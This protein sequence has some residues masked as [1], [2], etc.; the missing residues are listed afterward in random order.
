MIR[1]LTKKDFHNFVDFCKK[2]DINSDFYITKNEKRL[3]L[4]DSKVATQIFKDCLKG[5]EKCFVK[6]DNDSITGILLITGYKDKFERKFVKLFVNTDTDC[7]DLLYYLDWQNL[8]NLFIKCHKT[9]KNFIKFSEQ[10]KNF[11]P[12]YYL[13]KLGFQIIA[14]REKEVLL[15]R[16]GV[17]RVYNQPSK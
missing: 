12:S 8:K 13:R 3:F 17:K 5:R 6:E 14:V 7:Q 11:V 2:R 10:S 4:N 15:K 9:N 16:E 1:T